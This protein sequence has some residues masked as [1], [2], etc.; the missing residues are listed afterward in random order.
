MATR[1][2]AELVAAFSGTGK[3]QADFDTPMPEDSLDTAWPMT[4]D[5]YPNVDREIDRLLDCRQE[6]LVAKD[7]LRRIMRFTL[8]Y[9]ADPVLMTIHAAYLLSVAASPTGTPANQVTTF[10]RGVG[11]TAGLWRVGVVVGAFTK[12]TPWLAWNVSAADFKRAIENLSQ[13]GRGNTT[14]ILAAGPPNTWTVTLLNNLANGS[15]VFAIDNTG[16][17]GGVVTQTATTAAAQRMHAISRLTGYQPSAFGLVAG[18]RNSARLPKRYKSVVMDSFV[19]RGSA[20]QPRITA[21]MGVVGSGEVDI[22]TSGYVVPACEIFRAARFRDCGLIIDGVDYAATNLWKD[23]ELNVNNGLITDDDAYSAQDEDVHRL[24]RADSR[25]WTL[26]LGILGEEGD[27]IFE[28]GEQLAEVPMS[29]RIGRPGNCQLWDLPKASISLKNPSITYDGTAKRS[30]VE[31]QI[32]HM[33]IP[34]DATTPFTLSAF[35]GQST[36]FLEVAV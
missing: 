28:L 34:G 22:V 36:P 30:K 10:S 6:D 8:D 4:S 7:L 5:S 3:I 13:V 20:A 26:D 27:P 25:V 17:T 15:L 35:V 18:F 11:V 24:E 12:Y 2:R 23:F 21:S 32:E 29:L 31:L 1:R 19:V 9:D 16:L 14:V 33:T